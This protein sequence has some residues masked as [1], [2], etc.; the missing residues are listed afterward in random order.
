VRVGVVSR[1]GGLA[2]WLEPPKQI[3]DWKEWYVPRFGWVS[4]TVVYAMYLNRKQ[5]TLALVFSDLNSGQ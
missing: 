2:R 1:D 5:N 3:V 4:P